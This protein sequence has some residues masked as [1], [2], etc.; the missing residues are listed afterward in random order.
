[1]PPRVDAGQTSGCEACS[2][3]TSQSVEL[4]ARDVAELEWCRD[5]G[6]LV[7]EVRLRSEQLDGD[8]PD[9][10]LAKGEG[11]F[12]AGDSTAGDEYFLLSVG[13]HRVP[14]ARDTASLLPRVEIGDGRTH[15]LGRGFY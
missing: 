11:G 8:V 14:P 5:C 12:E 1:M 9:R 2:H 7:P 15:H 4:E 10:E 6:R 13:F 3:L